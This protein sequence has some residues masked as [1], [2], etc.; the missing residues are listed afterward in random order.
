MR[1]CV[2][3]RVWSAESTQ[4]R[5][6]WGHLAKEP[7]KKQRHGTRTSFLSFF[8]SRL[9]SFL[10]FLFLVLCFVI[11]LFFSSS[12]NHLRIVHINCPTLPASSSLP[13]PLLHH[14]TYIPHYPSLL[15]LFVFLLKHAAF[16]VS[17]CLVPR[18]QGLFRKLSP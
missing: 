1:E 11:P 12:L 13:T 2:S 17:E 10:L 18:P 8:F 14:T 6:R 5:S 9:F 7:I 16:K 15:I 4:S 3:V